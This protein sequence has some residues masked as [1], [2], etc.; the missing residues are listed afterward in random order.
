MSESGVPSMHR[1]IAVAVVTAAV[2]MA[3]GAG[4]EAPRTFVGEETVRVVEVPV[5]VSDAATG[6]PV[7]GL[8]PSDFRIL[9][10]GVEQQI[11]NFAEVSTAART[12][13]GRSAGEVEMVYFFDL[14]MMAGRDRDRAVAG[15]RE[16]YREGLP[17]GRRVSVVSY[18]GTLRSHL[19][20]SRD[21]GEVALA[22]DEIARRPSDAYG[23]VLNLV[24]AQSDGPIR[25][26]NDLDVGE[27]KQRSREFLSAL[28]GRV[29]RVGE[30]LSAT[31]ARFADSDARRVLV[32]FTPGHPETEWAP[33]YSPEDYFGRAG[34]D[35]VGGMWQRLALEAA[36]LGFTCFLLDP[37]G[38]RFD[39]RFEAA[40]STRGLVQGSRLASTILARGQAQTDTTGG[41]RPRPDVSEP[42]TE[43]LERSRRSLLLLTADV[44]GGGVAFGADTAAA[45]RQVQA[46]LDHYYSLA[47]APGHLG[48]GRTHQLQVE[49]RGR[50]G[51]ALDHRTAYVDQPPST[52]RDRRVEAAM[53]FG[54]DTNPLEVRVEVGEATGR[55]RVR[56][57]LE[58][59]IPYAELT[60]L[61]RGDIYWGKLMVTFFNQSASGTESKVMNL[62]QPV[63]VPAER[64]ADAL[65][66]GYFSYK[67]TV[68][69]ERGDHD[70][71]IGIRDLVGERL[72]LLPQQ[73]DY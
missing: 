35:A 21:A 11:T 8:E 36:D 5:R 33:T 31:M 40:Y 69:M 68:E 57:P 20:R 3:A 30:A 14:F 65:A 70:L 73:L 7:T 55:R 15:V 24:E 28:R 42:L 6:E 50:D 67:V 48:D 72:S 9:E 37:S 27:R 71:Y 38:A 66:E 1:L 63:M 59:Q 19:E 29:E 23:R 51:L 16:V 34:R 39:D 25:L 17:P 18:D 26:D 22:L 2:G 10:D 4:G 32:A 45:L 60:L 62:E 54:V 46:S 58:L 64:Y 56:V 61:D 13:S 49:V 52:V 47:Y 41:R 44:T 43:W 12:E 53:T